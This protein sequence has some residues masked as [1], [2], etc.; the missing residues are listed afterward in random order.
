MRLVG[1]FEVT[2]TVM[3]LR[4]EERVA[5]AIERLMRSDDAW[6][7]LV[8]E[9]VDRWPDEAPL[10]LGFALVSA[11]S[12]IESSFTKSSPVRDAAMQGYRLAALISMDVYAMQLLDM[13]CDKAQDLIAYWDI[14]PF[15]ARL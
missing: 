1:S 3:S 14:D 12:A 15:F 5:F 9:M 7:G 6:R 8:R 2:M 13:K 11:A 4:I 10:E